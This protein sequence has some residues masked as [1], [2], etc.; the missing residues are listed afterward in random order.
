MNSPAYRRL[1]LLALSVA[2]VVEAAWLLIEHFAH[3]AGLDRLGQPVVFFALFAVLAI[4]RGR[5]FW[6]PLVIRIFFAYEFGSAVAD[7][8]GWLG[9]PGSG[10]SWGDFAHFVAYTHTVNAFLPASF[11]FPLAVLATIAEGTFT[12]TLLLG[13]RTRLACLGA[14]VLLFLFASAMTASGLAPGQFYYAV[15]LL[16]AGAWYMSAIDPTWLSVDRFW[17]RHG[18]QAVAAPA[19]SE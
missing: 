4:L 5:L 7:R 8:L 10:V 14:A 6:Y 1:A 3:H 13:I 2:L 19:T 12:I 17:A 15:F 16:A 11:A 18:S 9:P